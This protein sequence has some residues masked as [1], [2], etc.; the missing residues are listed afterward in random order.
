M[1]LIVTTGSEIHTSSFACL[2]VK[3]K[4]GEFDGMHLYQVPRFKVHVNWDEANDK[5]SNWADSEYDLPEGTQITIVALQGEN[6]RD[7]RK[8]KVY[9]VYQ[10][11]PTA[12]LVEEEID[13]TLRSCLIKGRLTRIIP[14]ESE[15][16]D[17]TGGFEEQQGAYKEFKVEGGWRVAWMEEG[18][19]PRLIDGSIL[20]KAKHPAQVKADKLNQMKEV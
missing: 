5:H 4:G 10:L 3:F 6:P 7:K 15:P 17:Y 11:D 9:R 12:E 16:I 14:K 18:K 13:L 20:Y 2:K 1:K 19:L 8:K